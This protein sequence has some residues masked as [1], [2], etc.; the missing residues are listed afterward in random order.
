MLSAHFTTG[1]LVFHLLIY[2]CFVSEVAVVKGKFFPLCFLTGIYGL[3]GS[4]RLFFF[5]GAVL[6][7]QQIERK[8]RDFLCTL[9]PQ[10]RITTPLSTSLTRWVY[11]LPGMNLH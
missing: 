8:D 6:G 10:A 7:L 2:D 5:F 3:R 11:F 1:I 4:C 9:C